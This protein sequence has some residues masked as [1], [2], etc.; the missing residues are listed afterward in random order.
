M[1]IQVEIQGVSPY[2]AAI[3]ALLEVGTASPFIAGLYA[4]PLRNLQH[5]RSPQP[6]QY[7]HHGRPPVILSSSLQLCDIFGEIWSWSPNRGATDGR[8]QIHTT[9]YEQEITTGLD[10]AATDARRRRTT[11]RDSQR[12]LYGIPPGEQHMSTEHP[13]DRVC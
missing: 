13:Y 11:Q 9:A 2:A 10:I 8:P 1:V 3:F 6:I 7:S 4:D 5:D 12:R